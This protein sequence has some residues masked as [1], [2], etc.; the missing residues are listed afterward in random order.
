[1]LSLDRYWLRRVFKI[2]LSFFLYLFSSYTLYHLSSSR[3]IEGGNVSST[4]HAHFIAKRDASRDAMVQFE[5]TLFWSVANAGCEEFADWMELYLCNRS[6]FRLVS[7]NR[8]CEH[9]LEKSYR[10]K[11]I[12]MLELRQRRKFVWC[13]KSIDDHR[14][15]IDLKIL[16]RFNRRNNSCLKFSATS[17]LTLTSG[18]AKIGYK[19]L[20]SRNR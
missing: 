7:K 2:S 4:F 5:T 14:R 10:S 18:A 12:L 8:G 20:N 1:M 3:D 19:C 16:D 15:N 17:D 6:D 9:R 13:S 11:Q